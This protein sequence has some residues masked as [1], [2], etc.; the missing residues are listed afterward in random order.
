MTKL[1]GAVDSGQHAAPARPG[2]CWNCG[3]EILPGQL[4]RADVWK[5]LGPRHVACP[6]KRQV[7]AAKR[8]GR[9]T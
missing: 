8:W 4:Y 5:A 3:H 1:A 9:W 6:T 2:R 7:E